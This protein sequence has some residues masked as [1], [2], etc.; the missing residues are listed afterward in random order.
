MK[1]L[2]KV[3]LIKLDLLQQSQDVSAVVV[4]GVVN[5]TLISLV[6]QIA[7]SAATFLL[8]LVYGYFLGDAKF[9][10]LYGA[11]GL[12]LLVGIPLECGFNQQITRREPCSLRSMREYSLFSCRDHNLTASDPQI[13]SG[14]VDCT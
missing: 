10:E 12:V 4:K 5:N 7:I 3:I 9:G 8:T 13:G 6:G 11:M 1:K 2:R 14:T